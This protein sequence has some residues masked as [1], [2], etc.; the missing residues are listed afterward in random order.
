MIFRYSPYLLVALVTVGGPCSLAKAAD[1]PMWRYDAGRCGA[2]P[3]ALPAELHLQWVREYP[4][5]QPAWPEQD[6]MQFDVAYEPIVQGKTL[7]LSSSRHDCVRA[8][9]TVTGAEKWTFFADGPV[10]FAPVAWHGKLY[11]TADD[12]YLYCLDG[13]TGKLIWKSRGGPGERKILGNERLISMWPARG[14]PVIADDGTLYFT[15]SIWPFM[16]IFVHAVDAETG[17]VRW[18]NDGDGSVYMKQPHF[19]DAF[20]GIAPQ[21]PLVVAG[22]LL[23]LPCGRSIPACFDRRTG[24]LLRYQLAENGKRGG[25]SE[26]AALGQVF[27]NGGAFF[28]LTTEKYLADYG[29]P[30]VLTPEVAYLYANGACRAYDFAR[31]GF[32]TR[33]SSRGEVGRIA[34]TSSSTPLPGGEKG[35]SAW[36]MDEMASCKLDLAEA[37]IK[38]GTRLY[39]GGQDY[40]QAL[41]LDLANKTMT[42]AWRAEIE[43]KVVRLVAADDRLFAVTREGQIHCFAGGK[44]TPTY[45]VWEKVRTHRNALASSKAKRVLEATGTREGYCIVWGLDSALLARE[46]VRQSDL[47]V[48]V[49]E[50]DGD[51]VLQWRKEWSLEDL[52]GARIEIVQGNPMTVSLPPYLTSLQVCEDVRAIGLLPGPEFLVPA[53]RTLR[54][55]G[56]TLCFFNAEQGR[57]LSARASAFGLEKASYRLVDEFTLL[58]RDGGL[59][60]AANW[61][62][63][64]ADSANTRVSRDKLVKAPLGLLW[65]GGPSHEGILPRHGHG[66]QPQVID[67]RII[68]EGIDLMRA[69]DIYTGRLLWET[70]LPGVGAFFNNLSHQ[71]GANASGS[72]FVSTRDAIYV[73]FDTSCLLLDPANGSKIDE[74]RLPVLPGMKGR[75]RWGYVNVH[76]DYLI[77]GLDPLLDEKKLPMAFAG[78]GDDTDSL[79]ESKL[80]RLLKSFKSSSDN[81]SSSKHIAVMDRFTGRVLW[82]ASARCGF[83]HNATCLGGGRL[84]TVDRLSGDQIADYK[85]KGLE[86]P[87]P[88]LVALDLKTGKVVWS[89]ESVFGTWLSYSEKHDVLVEAGRVTRDTLLDEPKGMRGYRAKDGVVLWY[90]RGYTGPAMIHGDDVLQGQAACDVLTGA[91]KLRQ[92]PITG[93]AVPWGWLRNYGCNTPAAS[94]HLLTFRSGAAGYFDLNN[95]SGTGN[96]GGFRSS[97]TNNLIV[98]G[99][100]LTAPEYTRTCTCAYQNQCSV[101]LV[102]MPEAEMWTFYGPGEVKGV[103]KRLGLNFGA[104]GDRKAEDGTLW[105]EY[106][107]VAGTS[108]AVKV[109]TVPATPDFFR[110]HPSQVSGPYSW[111]ASS[112]MRG[113]QSISIDLGPEA[114]LPRK[115]TVRLFFAEPDP[116][117]PG[118]RVFDVTIQG[119]PVLK[120]F[121]VLKAAGGPFR[122]VIKEFNGVE[123]AQS[124]TVALRPSSLA[125]VRAPL[126][127][128]ME[129]VAEE[130]KE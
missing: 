129:L 88:R 25:G 27:Y 31:A 20:A 56:G 86:L 128:G 120:D 33:L 94:E 47:R 74:F 37:I 44:T 125:Q 60:G 9:D 40:L 99:G 104:P 14:A 19:A 5:L 127:C 111:I 3:Q 17:T 122:S 34:N 48:I 58:T 130:K 121:D 50:P 79:K 23:L 71:P 124:L 55:Y 13:L 123:A 29:R 42:P 109:K 107:S 101:A 16:G 115:Y 51:K 28:D 97:C 7:Y 59:P 66:P 12:G 22:D 43:G 73:V 84:Y 46:L 4:P 70:S 68:I 85:R 24:K 103:V 114:R 2:S 61:T 81:L 57:E 36:T 26:V 15:A 75:P 67:G 91:P 30:A 78:N 10:R 82:I 39:V 87:E 69:L 83:R 72:N 117:R 32:R 63:E 8:L 112:G 96:F 54:P 11:F 93:R 18:T 126:L 45:H 105:L 49:V 6:K 119:R 102:H 118:Q 80:S 38:A 116:V 65:F 92:D 76:D 90:E 108:P 21:G 98:A 64:H 110:R 62:H 41:D 95:D 77:G 53:Y 35:D 113:I 106:P 1:W 89:A 52:Y 100:I